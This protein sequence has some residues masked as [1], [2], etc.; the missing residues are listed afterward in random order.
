MTN[1][2]ELADMLQ[3]QLVAMDRLL[4]A[5]DRTTRAVRSLAAVSAFLLL[6]LVLATAP[7]LIGLLIGLQSPWGAVL[8]ALGALIVCA[9]AVLGVTIAIREFYRSEVPNS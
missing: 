7:V 5:Q 4:E 9:G 6:G 2:E 1:S 8:I 3:E